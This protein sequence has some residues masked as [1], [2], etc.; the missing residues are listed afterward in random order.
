MAAIKISN[1]GAMI[2]IRDTTLLPNDAA[3]YCSNAWL[4]KGTI[5]GFRKNA[6]VYNCLSAST[7]YVYRIPNTSDAKPDFLNSTWIEFADRYTNVV[8]APMIEDQYHRY[9][10]FSP[11]QAPSYNTLARIQAGTPALTL[12]IPSP[13]TAPTLSCSGGTPTSQEVRSYIYTWVSIYGEEG[14]PSPPTT[15]LGTTDGTWVVGVSAPLP[16]D[17]QG[18]KLAT[19]NIYRTVS[20]GAGNSQFYQLASLPIGTAIYIDT[21]LDTAITGKEVLPSNTFSAP[22][23]NLQGCVVMA[24]GMLAAWANE[25]ELWFCEPYYPHAWNPG[26]TISV[27]AKIVGLAAIG[28]SLMIMTEGSPWIATGVTPGTITLGKIAAKEPCISR[29]S[30][31]ASGEGGYYASLNGLVCLNTGGTQLVTQS[32]LTKQDWVALDPYDF[33]SARYTTSYMAFVSGADPNGDNGVLLDLA[34]R[35]MTFGNLAFSGGVQNVMQDELSGD[36]FVL[37]NQ[38]VFQFDPEV[39]TLLTPYKWTSK[40]FQFPYAQQFIGAKI[41]FTVPPALTIPL[42]SAVTRNTSQTQQFDPTS[43]Y[44]LLR[45]YA[46]GN[47]LLVRE[48]QKSGELIMFPSGTIASLWVFALEGQVNVL[49]LQAATSIKELRNV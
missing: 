36:V 41:Y 49:N 48:V 33:M 7:N 34:D 46:D 31:V 23:S 37:S 10:F 17:L 4:Y 22:P 26:Y 27:D 9:Y 1:F 29:S 40:T 28:T 32:Q 16:A 35:N 24:N 25:V 20:D 47:L 39:A 15:L 18:R 38:T 6:P 13:E 3:S 5:Q 45:V 21:Q 42:P 43:Q 11:S 8:R 12:G 19:L 14:P 2:P 44:L 30:I